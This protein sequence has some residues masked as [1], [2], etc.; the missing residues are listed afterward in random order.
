MVCISVINF[1]L[2]QKKQ[3]S[4][5][6]QCQRTALQLYLSKSVAPFLFCS[7]EGMTWSSLDSSHFNYFNLK[8]FTF[9][10]LPSLFRGSTGKDFG[11][12][13]ADVSVAAWD[14][15]ASDHTDAQT[16]PC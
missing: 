11:N 4:A 15:F 9:K 14:L 16:I 8:E 6:R 10:N 3:K 1:I 13:G 7:L 12:I 5:K 2:K